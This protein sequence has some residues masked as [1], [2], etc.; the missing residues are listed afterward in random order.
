MGDSLNPTLALWPVLVQIILTISVFLVMGARKAKAVKAGLVDRKKAALN[1]S[2]WPDDVV[3]VSNNIQNQFQT[4][5]LFYVLVFAFILTNAVTPYV[6][7]LA[8]LYAIS[9]VAH[10]Y[11]HTGS[12]YVPARF[13]IFIF[14]VLT[15]VL[16]VG[17]LATQLIS[18]NG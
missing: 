11:V 12:N 5:V 15:L 17:A 4:P 3:Q 1:N 16:M 7:T 2:A 6:L 18:M 10:A 13:R 9:R 14:S 8:W